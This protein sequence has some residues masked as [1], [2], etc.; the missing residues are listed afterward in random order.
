MLLLLHAVQQCAAGQGHPLCPQ[1]FKSHHGVRRRR[2]PVLCR[3]WHAP[4]PRGRG[5]GPGCAVLGD[6]EENVFSKVFNVNR[7]FFGTAVGGGRGAQAE[8]KDEQVQE[9]AEEEGDRSQA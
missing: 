8:D 2:Y 5:F 9:E 7:V 3:L 6:D 4:S 1:V